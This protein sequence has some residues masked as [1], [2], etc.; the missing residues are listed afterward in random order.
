MKY[1]LKVTTPGDREIVLTRTFDA[2]RHL[3]FEAMTIPEHVRRWLLGPPGWSM[4]VCE[5]E[6]KVGGRYRYVWRNVDGSE[7]GMHGV[8]REINPPE[9]IVSTETFDFGCDAQSGES[10]VTAILTEQAGRTTFTATVLAPSKE[11]RDAVIASGMEHGA[12]ASYDRLEELLA[13][14]SATA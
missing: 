9:R 10:L 8:Y 7:M 11:A 1:K 3:V 2:L 13:E 4:I 14:T 5:I 12:G 6:L